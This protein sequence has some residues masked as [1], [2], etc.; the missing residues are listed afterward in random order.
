MSMLYPRRI[1][2]VA[3]KKFKEEGTSHKGLT[4]ADEGDS[5]F[6]CMF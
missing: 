4:K 3:K 2:V 6:G 5:S 1:P